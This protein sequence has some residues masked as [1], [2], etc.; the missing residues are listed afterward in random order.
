MSHE[1][2]TYKIIEKGGGVLEKTPAL[3]DK[4]GNEIPKGTKIVFN[5]SHLKK[6]DHHRIRFTID[7]FGE[8][9]LRFAP[10]KEDVMWV[11]P[12]SS[13]PSSGDRMDDVFWVDKMHDDGKWIDVINMNL[14]VEDFYFILN[15]VKKNTTSPLIGLDPPGGNENSGGPGSGLMLSGYLTTG[16]ATGAIVGLGTA[17]FASEYFVEQNLLVYGIGGALVGLL[18]GILAS[19]L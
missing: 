10:K 9:D 2:R 15:F 8:S 19:R 1:D 12:G 6:V 7:K 5:K 4:N 18:L 14:K 11:C 16:I 3:A 17:A 13:P